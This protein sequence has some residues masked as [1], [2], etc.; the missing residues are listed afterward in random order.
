MLLNH[1]ALARVTYFVLFSAMSS[2]GYATTP[3]GCQADLTTSV[4]AEVFRTPRLSISQRLIL[5]AHPITAL[6]SSQSVTSIKLVPR[7]EGVDS[8][9]I[10]GEDKQ[11]VFLE[12]IMR[13]LYPQ[14]VVT[15]GDKK[16]KPDGRDDLFFRIEDTAE[17]DIRSNIP[18]Q[19]SLEMSDIKAANGS[20]GMKLP[21][22]LNLPHKM[23]VHLY[24]R[25]PFM[26]RENFDREKNPDLK[27][28]LE[29][30]LSLGEKIVVLSSRQLR[31]FDQSLVLL[32]GEAPAALKLFDHVLPLSGLKKQP[33]PR[34]RILLINDTMGA[35]SEIHQEAKLVYVQGPINFFE[36]LYTET[37]TYVLAG[38]M[39][40]DGYRDSAIEK[41]L[42]YGE[43]FPNFV[44][45]QSLSQLNMKPRKLAGPHFEPT[46]F[47]DFLD[48]LLRKLEKQMRQQAAGPGKE[49]IR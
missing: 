22:T 31:R 35:M 13:E 29:K 24:L 47:G 2:P 43:D 17:S 3:V 12:T 32:Q 42:A 26:A 46:A 39:T 23:F 1:F 38:P 45:L 11:V 40:R 10:G 15:G 18:S 8:F 14:I 37:A 27:L 7:R 28:V 33:L 41:M 21:L 20:F 30:M 19:F 6:A 49:A 44:E 36:A 4:A 5:R 25:D 16:E 48:I 9:Q 34:G